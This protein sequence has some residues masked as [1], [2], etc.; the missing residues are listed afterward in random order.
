MNAGYSPSGWMKNRGTV[1]GPVFDTFAL[2]EAAGVAWA[3]NVCVERL[4]VSTGTLDHPL[5][6]LEVDRPL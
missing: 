2:A 4:F 1:S 6:L 5:E 3:T